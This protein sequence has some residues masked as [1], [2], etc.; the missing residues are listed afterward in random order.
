MS[1]K[2]NI[3]IAV[4]GIDI[5]KNSF[6]VVGHDERGAIV[7]R[8]KG[9]RALIRQ[10]SIE[11]ASTRLPQIRKKCRLLFREGSCNLISQRLHQIGD[12]GS[13]A[14]LYKGFDRH[15][16]QQLDIAKPRHL[17]QW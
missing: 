12:N 8:Q 9:L 10:M 4:I 15:A 2:L 17:L 16:G 3:A 7:L 14:G 13:F 11:K 6:H 1:Q 5:G